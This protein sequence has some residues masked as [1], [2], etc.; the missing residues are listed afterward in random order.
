MVIGSTLA[1]FGE[2]LEPTRE[3]KRERELFNQ[4]KEKLEE[5]DERVPLFRGVWNP[6]FLSHAPSLLNQ[7][8]WGKQ[9]VDPAKI[10]KR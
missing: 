4:R 10:N 7:D 6:V 3:K 8:H 9:K 2:R 1:S 5:R